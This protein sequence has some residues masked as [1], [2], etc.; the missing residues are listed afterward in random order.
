MIRSMFI[1]TLGMKFLWLT[2]IAFAHMG[3]F[4]LL[5]NRLLTFR[6]GILPKP[7]PYESAEGK[8]RW[9]SGPEGSSVLTFKPGFVLRPRRAHL[10]AP[11]AN[12]SEIDN[13]L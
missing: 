2:N 8:G 11:K 12:S 5:K 3:P 13:Q 10:L 1:C 9:N 6:M 7:G 4:V